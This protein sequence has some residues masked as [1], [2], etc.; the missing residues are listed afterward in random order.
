MIK[1]VHLPG[2]RTQTLESFWN[3]TST[4]FFKAP[5]GAI[6]N[7]KYGKGRW[8]SVNVQK[9]T[10]DGNSVKKLVVGSGSLVYARM[11]MKVPVASD[12][13]YEVMPGDVAQ[14]TPEF[15]GHF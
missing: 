4:A 2:G 15:L 8:S 12:V 7:V 9:Q 5:V 3:T 1:T 6:I 13:T 11:R 10:L 14:S